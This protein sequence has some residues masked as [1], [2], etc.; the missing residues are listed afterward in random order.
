MKAEKKLIIGQRTKKNLNKQQQTFNRLI[1]K[2]EK[3]RL[4]KET[5]DKTLSKNLDFYGKHLH[6]LEEKLTGLHEQA[7]KIFYKFYCGKNKFAK[8]DKDIL[9]Q[10]IAAQMSEFSSFSNKL[11]DKM[12][13]IYEFIEGESYEKSVES[14]F[15]AMKDDMS[16]TFGKMGFEI[17]L[18]GFTAD[19]SEAEMMK[20]M[21]E[22]MENVKDRAENKF[23]EEESKRKKTKKQ[24]EKEIRDNQVE[25][26]KNKNIASLYKQLARIFHPDLE[27]DAE[28]KL[29]KEDLMK[30]LTVAY[31]KGDL[32]TLLRLELEWLQKE[33]DNLDKLSDEKLKIYNQALK[34]Q[35]EELEEEIH[36]STEHPRYLPLQRYAQIFDIESLDLKYE[37]EKL[38]QK[39]IEMEKD[40]V[41]LT[42][43]NALA[44]LKDII[45]AAKQQIRNKP[46]FDFDFDLLQELFK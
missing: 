26:A 25:E 30:Q 18:D 28:K 33:E 43:E 11:D 42:G 46:K 13:E 8:S 22:M 45:R 38:E 27:Q 36:F 41:K 7:A 24:L 19:L 15:Q 10:M 35:I 21:L 39:Y 32:H 23:A 1:K 40:M 12:K 17:D 20:K 2:L 34:E 31:E 9:F 3:M 6:P 4:Q 29:E 16:E 5:T 14:D 44:A 37:K